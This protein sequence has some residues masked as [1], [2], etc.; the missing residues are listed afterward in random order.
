M[1]EKEEEGKVATAGERK[2]GERETFFAPQFYLLALV[3]IETMNLAQWL[4]HAMALAGGG[5]R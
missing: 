1:K 2:S 3:V 4:L 5:I